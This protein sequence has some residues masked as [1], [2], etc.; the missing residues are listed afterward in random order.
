MSET[1][2]I[3]GPMRNR[4]GFNF[5]AFFRKQ[6]ELEEEGK[7]V[8]N[9]AEH[10]TQAHPEIDF[11]NNGPLPNGFMREALA[12]DCARICESDA[13]Y[14]LDGWFESEGV[15]RIELPLAE[16][17]GLKVYQEGMVFDDDR[18]TPYI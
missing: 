2:Y 16:V 7:I 17:L 1:V 8:F 9:P 3:A 6:R 13:I 10:D 11:A 4:P 15:T 14:L 18:F 12:W 5:D